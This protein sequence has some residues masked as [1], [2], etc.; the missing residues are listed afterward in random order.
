M[1]TT[2]PAS[3]R[4][5]GWPLRSVPRIRR[6]TSGFRS[7]HTFDTRHK[8]WKCFSWGTR[9]KTPR[10]AGR[11]QKNTDTSAPAGASGD[12]S[13]PGPGDPRALELIIWSRLDWV[14]FGLLV[15]AVFFDGCLRLVGTPRSAECGNAAELTTPPVTTR[16]YAG[17]GTLLG[18]YARERRVFVPIASCPSWW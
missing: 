9:S 5:N 4:P 12:P 18:E 6:H 3:A 7:V 17:D 13:E 16:V 10:Q 2:G 8:K 15:L 14:V 11:M 1:L